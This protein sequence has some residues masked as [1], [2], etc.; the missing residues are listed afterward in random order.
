MGF[1]D[2][3][4][5]MFKKE[6]PI[7]GSIDGGPIVTGGSA[8]GAEIVGDQGAAK[9]VDFPEQPVQPGKPEQ[10]EQSEQPE[11]P[12]EDVVDMAGGAVGDEAGVIAEKP[13]EPETVEKEV[14]SVEVEPLEKV[15]EVKQAPVSNPAT[16][17]EELEA[18]IGTGAEPEIM[19]QEGG[20]EEMDKP[21]E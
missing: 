15:E 21:E 10:S 8:D 5:A 9:T 16:S 2:K 7:E 4:F 3:I 14:A 19:A 1:L 20:P 11:Q 18:K 17:I 6:S 12:K 13:V